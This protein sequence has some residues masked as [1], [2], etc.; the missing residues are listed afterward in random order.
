[1]YVCACVCVCVCVCALCVSVFVGWVGGWVCVCV[2]MW[3]CVYVCVRVCVCVCV[4]VCVFVCVSVFVGGVCVCVC[5]QCFILPPIWGGLGGANG[6]G[7]PLAK[8]SGGGRSPL[9]FCSVG[10]NLVYFG[11]FLGFFSW[12]WDGFSTFSPAALKIRPLLYPFG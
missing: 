4:C 10:A 1:M 9:E 6:V 8:C 11:R 2:C 5:V 3:V 12:F 7:P